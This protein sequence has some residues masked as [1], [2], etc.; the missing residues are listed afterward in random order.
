[1]MMTDQPDGTQQPGELVLSGSR[2][3]NI[4]RG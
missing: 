4:G 2:S 1:L 3:V